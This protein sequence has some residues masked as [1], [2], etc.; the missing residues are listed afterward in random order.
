MARSGLVVLPREDR[1][2]RVVQPQAADE[3]QA[4]ERSGAHGEIDDDQVGLLAAIEAEAVGETLGLHDALHAGE[5]QQLAATLQNDR[6]V[7]DD[8]DLSHDT[9]MPSLSL[10]PSAARFWIG[11]MMSRVVP[12]VGAL[13][14]MN[15]P[16]RA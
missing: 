2:A 1:G 3:G 12:R 6:M 10:D 9:W 7:V 11:R 13:S 16:S 5:F 8:E 4:T 15:D 14:M